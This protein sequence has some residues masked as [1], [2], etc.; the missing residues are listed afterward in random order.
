MKELDFEKDLI[1]HLSQE[2]KLNEKIAIAE[3]SAPN[4]KSSSFRDVGDYVV[5]K[6]VEVRTEHQDY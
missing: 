4:T 3:E 6:D 1:Q 2:R 5:N